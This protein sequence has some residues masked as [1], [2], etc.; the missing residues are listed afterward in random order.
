M[1]FFK[2]AFGALL[3][4]FGI[5]SVAAGTFEVVAR[6]R[7]PGRLF[8]RGL[9]PL[10][11]AQRSDGWSPDEWRKGGALVFGLGVVFLLGT[12]SVLVP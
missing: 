2:L 9:F 10:N 3:A 4:L 1:V 6:R 12:A 7:P 8:G 5:M 11:G